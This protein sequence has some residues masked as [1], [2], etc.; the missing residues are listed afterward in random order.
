MANRIEVRTVSK[1][2]IQFWL[3]ENDFPSKYIYILLR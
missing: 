1:V 2:D 3:S